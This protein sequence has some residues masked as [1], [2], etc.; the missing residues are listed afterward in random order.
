MRLMKLGR[1]ALIA[2]LALGCFAAEISTASAQ[3]G[4]IIIRTAPPPP[5]AEARGSLR[6]G[7]EWVPGYWR[8]EGRRH[9]WV[10]GHWERARSG[11]VWQPARWDH[12]YNGWVFIPGRWVRGNSRPA[13][14]PP[15]RGG[16][17][18][19]PP[20]P[21]Q[22][23]WN[24]PDWRRQGWQM[25]GEQWVQ[26]RGRRAD[27]DTIYVG[28]NQGF[29][30]HVMLVA[31]ESDIELHDILITFSN[32]RTYQPQVRHYFRE[33]SRSRVIDLP[34]GPRHIESIQFVYGNLRGGGRARLQVWAR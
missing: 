24:R 17:Y 26:G 4:E 33:N 12:R 29:F 28:K 31:E 10:S 25:L 34:K 15:P 16:G 11:Y 5:R 8:W 21:R 7:Y 23:G 2:T 22:G 19:R 27:R 3:S 32:G 18:D 1:L 14:L 13:P 30:N 6:A 20:P 9:A